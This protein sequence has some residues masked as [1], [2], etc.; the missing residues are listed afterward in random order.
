MR[1]AYSWS[2]SNEISD[3]TLFTRH[4]AGGRNM[5]AADARVTLDAAVASS[6]TALVQDQIAI[7]RALGGGWNAGALEARGRS[8]R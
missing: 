4:L 8:L 6:D 2:D 1:V 3:V 7:F 5:V